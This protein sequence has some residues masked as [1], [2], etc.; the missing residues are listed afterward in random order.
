[1]DGTGQVRTVT[2][3]DT[4]DFAGYVVG[5]GALGVVTQVTLAIEKE[6]SVAQHV[7]RGMPWEQVLADYD[8]VT[9]RAY[10]VSLFTDWS[11]DT[12]GQVWFK[13]R[14]GGGRCAEYPQELL[15]GIAATEASHPI[16]GV[17]AINCTAQLGE[18]GSWRDRLSHFRMDFMP[19]AGAEIQSEYLVDR[20]HAVAAI[21]ALRALTEIITPLLQVAEI[22]S[23]AAD[24]LWLSTAEGRDSVAF[25]FT[26]FRD[27]D[28]V[29]E[30]AKI[31][32]AALAPFAARPHW[33][34]VFAADAA[35]LAPLYPRLADFKTLAETL[36]PQRK[37]RNDFLQ[38]TVLGA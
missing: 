27:Q 24:D 7:Y 3:T 21:Q 25:H 8:A 12:V 4:P 14:M 32:E 28:A 20:V 33:G 6:F 5:L 1:M 29:E 36:D 18:V 35:T 17:S 37:F 9:S 31:V 2:R 16:P 30:V 19:S 26:W 22:R 10:S 13:Q 23:V 34:K 11:G 38:R 15:G